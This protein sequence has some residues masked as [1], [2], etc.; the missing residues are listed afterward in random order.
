MTINKKYV[1]IT[2]YNYRADYNNEIKNLKIFQL[3]VINIT[4]TFMRYTYIRVL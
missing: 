4:F 2:I 3:V 1:G